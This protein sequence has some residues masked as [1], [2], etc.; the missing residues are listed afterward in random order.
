MIPEI[1]KMEGNTVDDIKELTESLKNNVRILDSFVRSIPP[2]HLQ[3]RRRP[4]VWTAA[5]HLDHLA[6]V[7]P[8]L[9]ERI[10]AFHHEDR[11]RFTPYIPS[12]D[13]TAQTPAI[14]DTETAVKEFTLW[15]GKQVVLL[16]STIGSL[17]EKTAEHPEYL[18]YSLYILARHILMHDHW[19]MYR[20]E[21]LWLTRDEYLS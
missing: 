18:N 20:M 4:D 6:A 13:E 11:P 5:E 16:E 9:Y 8:M 12:E 19:H 2:E 7:Q 14:M 17:W 3:Q 15:R 10:N 1:E 21:A